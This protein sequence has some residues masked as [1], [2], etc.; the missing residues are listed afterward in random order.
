MVLDHP[1]LGDAIAEN[2]L[3]PIDKFLRG[4]DLQEIRDRTLG[5]SY[6]SYEMGGHQWALPLDASVQVSAGRRDLLEIEWPRTFSDVERASTNTQGFVM[7]LAGP[8]AFLS[9]LSLCGGLNRNFG[10]PEQE[11]FH[12]QHEDAIELFLMLAGRS[13]LAGLELNPIGI[14]NSM[15]EGTLAYCPLI[16]GYVPYAAVTK[17]S[18]IT[19]QDAPQALSS[20]KPCGVLGGTG[21]ALTANCR[22]DSLLR[23]HL[24][25]LLSPDFQDGMIP[26]TS[27]QPSA[28]SAWQSSSVND[29][30]NGFYA[31]TMNT[32]QYALVRPRHRGYCATQCLAAA[33]IRD[34]HR[35]IDARTLRCNLNAILR[36][37]STK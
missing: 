12:S 20:S 24:L 8:H 13:E 22:P 2:C 3:L 10:H 9:L 34:K 36:A 15:V 21:I 37:G 4:D 32:M 16:F 33:Y 11:Y 30:V 18:V 5:A 23:A 14:L 7:S 17:R 6:E 28:K 26:E 27:G 31:E 19:F 1:H 35:S 25:A 29:T